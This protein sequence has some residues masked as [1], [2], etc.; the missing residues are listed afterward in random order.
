MAVASTR[1]R[2]ELIATPVADAAELLEKMEIAW[3]AGS[4]LDAFRDEL[5]HDFRTLAEKVA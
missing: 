4:D 5:F 3:A 2:Y 1:A